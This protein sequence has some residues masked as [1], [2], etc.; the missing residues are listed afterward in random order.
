MITNFIQRRF[1]QD[2]NWQN[3]NCYY[4]AKILIAR[5]PELC[6]YYLPVQ[7][8]FVAGQDNIFYDSTGVATLLE[9][10]Q[11]IKWEDLIKEDPSLAFRVTR[12][13][14]M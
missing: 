6:L 12:D 5:F 14:I 4:F 8:H 3:G 1:T 13:C 10:E 9:N 11:P 7:G 2:C